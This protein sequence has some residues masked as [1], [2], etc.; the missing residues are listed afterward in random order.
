MENIQHVG[1]KGKD[2]FLR[3]WWLPKV[4]LKKINISEYLSAFFLSLSKI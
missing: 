4:E 2:V 3:S 1:A